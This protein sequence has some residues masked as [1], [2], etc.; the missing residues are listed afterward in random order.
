MK[1]RWDNTF[2][3][4]EL[5]VGK[6]VF[7]LWLPCFGLVSTI[8]EICIEIMGFSLFELHLETDDESYVVLF[9]CTL[10][11]SAQN[12][13]SVYGPYG[14]YFG[15][16]C[17]IHVLLPFNFQLVGLYIDVKPIWIVFNV[18]F[19]FALYQTAPIVNNWLR[20]G[21]PFLKTFPYVWRK[22]RENLPV[23]NRCAHCGTLMWG[24][25]LD[26]Q[27]SKKNGGPFCSAFCSFITDP[28]QYLR[29]WPIQGYVR[30]YRFLLDLTE[31]QRYELDQAK[32][33]GRIP[34]INFEGGW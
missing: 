15:R 28:D 17:R 18:I 32:Q 13:W 25:R 19:D 34:T 6:W 3:G 22:F 1:L 27:I 9:G 8:V 29:S 7:G 11:W 16:V 23:L 33:A 30:Q 26:R 2:N 21:R 5:H 12:G 31:V 24:N 20:I 10:K 14:E 4:P